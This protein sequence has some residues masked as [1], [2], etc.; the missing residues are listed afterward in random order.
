MLKTVYATAEEIPEGYADL[1]TERNGQWELTGVQG[2]KTQSDIDR[3]QGALAKERNDHKITKQALAPYEGLD[4]EVIHTQANELEDVKA[5]LAA[6]KNDG[7]IDET[8]LEPLI[9]AR[10]AQKI[11][12]LERELRNTSAKLV[13]KDKLI[14]VKDGE[15]SGLKTTIITGNVDRAIRDAAIEAKLLPT[16]VIDAVMHGKTVFEVTEDGRIITKDN[17][18]ATPGLSVKE[19]LTDMKEKAPHW[20]PTSVGGGSQGGGPTGKNGYGGANNPWS[21]AGWNVTKQGALI[22]QL[23]AIKAGEIAAQA[24]CKIGDTKPAAAE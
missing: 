16:A 13:E 2:V 21:K 14:A 12:P 9:A 17:S 19:W 22:T 7:T 5:Q 20:W 23:G 4:P 6:I 1:Y 8:K 18:G 11:A 10:V 24:G 3:I 15:V